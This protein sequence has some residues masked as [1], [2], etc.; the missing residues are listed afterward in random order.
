MRIIETLDQFMEWAK[1][2][3]SWQYLFRGVS[4]ECYKLEVPILAVK[5]PIKGSCKVQ[6]SNSAQVIR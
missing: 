1:Q 4:S 3:T 2:L 5:T 6:S